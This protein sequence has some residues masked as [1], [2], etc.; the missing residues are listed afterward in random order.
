MADHN[1]RVLRVSDA[2]SCLNDPMKLRQLYRPSLQ[3]SDPIAAIFAAWTQSRRDNQVDEE[4]FYHARNDAE[5]SAEQMR[6]GVNVEARIKRLL[7]GADVLIKP[8]HGTPLRKILDA[9]VY[10]CSESGAPVYCSLPLL[11]PPD[12]DHLYRE[13]GWSEGVQWARVQPDLIKVSHDEAGGGFTLQLYGG[14]GPYSPAEQFQV[15]TYHLFL[16]LLLSSIKSNYP[17]SNARHLKMHTDVQVW[18]Y[19]GCCSREC[20][21]TGCFLNRNL[22]PTEL[23]AQVNGNG[24][25]FIV[26]DKVDLDMQHTSMSIESG[27]EVERFCVK[28]L[29]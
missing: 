23:E 21:R 14:Q 18:R 11:S 25:K 7:E 1:R 28:M 22:S 15:L 12:L 29:R 16:D 4:R 2:A 13:R 19:Y 24:R 8:P 17:S 5:S 10:R 27:V 9:L 20:R 6:H 3:T 26:P